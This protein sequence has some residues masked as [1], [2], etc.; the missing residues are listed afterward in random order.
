ME[1]AHASASIDAYSVL[2]NKNQ[3]KSY[4]RILTEK[5]KQ[6]PLLQLKG[7]LCQLA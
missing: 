7:R 3:L 4:K 5:A 6:Q 1:K 2:L